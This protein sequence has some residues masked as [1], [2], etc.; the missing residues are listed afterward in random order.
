MSIIVVSIALVLIACRNINK[1]RW[2]GGWSV[3]PLKRVHYVC[4]CTSAC[5][6]AIVTH[7]LFIGYCTGI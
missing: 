2:S 1:I 3:Q 4:A 7:Q 6:N 5:R